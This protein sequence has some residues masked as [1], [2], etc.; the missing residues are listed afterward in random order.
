[1]LS[2]FP[3]LNCLY[4]VQF[5]FETAE[6]RPG[7]VRNYNMPHTVSHFKLKNKKKSEKVLIIRVFA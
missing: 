4:S 7:V 2:S 6:I 5:C 1:M 3:L